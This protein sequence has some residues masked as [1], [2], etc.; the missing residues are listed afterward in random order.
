MA[1]SVYISALILASSAS[2]TTAFATIKTP[3]VFGS[4]V[5]PRVLYSAESSGEEKEEWTE[6]KVEQVGNLIA[7]DEWMGL[8]MEL[9]ELVRVSI[10]EE[11][12]K[13]TRDF[14][15]KD[16][17]KV[18][19]ITKEVDSRVKVRMYVCRSQRI[20]VFH[21]DWYYVCLNSLYSLTHT[22]MLFYFRPRLQSY[23][24]KKSM[25]SET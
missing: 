25:N 23:V 19:D 11:A 20:I 1:L 12:K 2:L 17:Y 9:S 18:G 13:N 24:E 22:Y 6:E 4:A 15:G 3:V 7:D 14:I 10:I 8:S 21:N 5:R 16:D